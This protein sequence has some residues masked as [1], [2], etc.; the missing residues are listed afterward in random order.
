MLHHW[1]LTLQPAA[2]QREILS[3][4]I[5]RYKVEENK[6]EYRGI[7]IEGYRRI[8]CIILRIL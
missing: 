6:E 3:L 8:F 4:I 2:N 7:C 1:F 5:I